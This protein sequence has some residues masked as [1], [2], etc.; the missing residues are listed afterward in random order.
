MP[1]ISCLIPL[2]RSGAFFDIICD[3]IDAHLPEDAEILVSDRHGLDDTAD[4]L[5][6]RYAQERRVRIVSRLDEADWISNINDLIRA[7]TGKYFRIIPHDDTATRCS[8]MRLVEA[9]DT[10]DDA[11]LAYGIV[12]AIDL[13]GAPLPHRDEL[14]ATES[15]TSKSWRQEDALSMFWQNRFLGAFKGVIR[16][17]LVR[18]RELLIRKTPTLILSE[19][20]WLFA[21]SL[22]GRFQFVPDSVLVKRYYDGSTSSTWQYTSKIFADIVDLMLNYIDSLIADPVLRAQARRSV[23]ENGQARVKA[24]EFGEPPPS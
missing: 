19:R 8:S 16:S 2:Y 23:I 9:L 14:N 22:T 24:M 15:P 7:A 6:A 10:N 3:N 4:R 20:V 12:R 17:E 1:R 18:S 13:S 11:V 21:L 5:A